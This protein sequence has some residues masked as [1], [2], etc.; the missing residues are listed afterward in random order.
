MPRGNWA[1]AVVGL[2]LVAGCKSSARECLDPGRHDYAACAKACAED[3]ADACHLHGIWLT[4]VVAG[5][6]PP[7]VDLALARTQ[8][9]RACDLGLAAGCETAAGYYERGE[10]GAAPDRATAKALAER[11]CKLGDK[12]ACVRLGAPRPA[13][14]G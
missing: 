13:D 14:S 10:A 2:F 6:P 8:Q 5:A 4:G 1:V 12:N 7:K 11:A 3:N 9:E